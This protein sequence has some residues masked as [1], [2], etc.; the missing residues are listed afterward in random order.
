MPAEGAARDRRSAQVSQ[1]ALNCR[2]ISCCGIDRSR[3]C[4]FAQAMASSA[5]SGS[6]SIDDNCPLPFGRLLFRVL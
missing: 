2:R 6:R 3:N 4:V 1:P 5:S